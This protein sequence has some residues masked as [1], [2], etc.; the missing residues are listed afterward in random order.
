[1]G[2]N[3]KKTPITIGIVPVSALSAECRIESILS[4]NFFNP[5]LNLNS[6]I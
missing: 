6:R 1:M 3:S 2:A 5:Y 4:K